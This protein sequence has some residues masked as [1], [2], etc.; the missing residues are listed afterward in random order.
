MEKLFKNPYVVKE[1][2]HHEK[3]VSL[4]DQE[5]IWIKLPDFTIEDRLKVGEK[6]EKIIVMKNVILI[7]KSR[8]LFVF[9]NKQKEQS[10]STANKWL[11]M[12]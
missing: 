8:E 9:S 1:D 4:I 11:E 5:I 12:F 7:A 3:V 10:S 2:T 6:V